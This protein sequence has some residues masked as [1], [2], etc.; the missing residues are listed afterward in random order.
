SIE[1]MPRIGP[2]LMGRAVLAATTEGPLETPIGDSGHS[3]TETLPIDALSSIAARRVGMHVR[4]SMVTRGS[5][6]EMDLSPVKAARVQKV[7]RALTSSEP[8]PDR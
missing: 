1:F 6:I 2:S 8:P 5:T 3:E 7:L 4:L